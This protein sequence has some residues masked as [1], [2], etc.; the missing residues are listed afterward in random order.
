MAVRKYVLIQPA[1][2]GARSDWP[3]LVLYTTDFSPGRA[4]PLQ[5]GLRTA[6]TRAV[7]DLQISEWIVENIKKGWNP[8]IAGAA[9]A[10][11]VIT[12]AEVS[13]ASAASDAAA[14][15]SAEKPKKA[16]KKPKG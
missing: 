1:E 5:T 9:P 6:A 16:A 15:A 4:E 7:A 12:A 11:A 2:S 14:P 13:P 3:P 8:A 10:A